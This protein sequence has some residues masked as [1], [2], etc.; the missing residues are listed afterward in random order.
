MDRS[1]QRGS[2]HRGARRPADVKRG[3]APAVAAYSRYAATKR[4][5]TPTASIA[6]IAARQHGV[7]THRRSS[8]AGIDEERHL[9]V[10][11]S[12]APAPRSSRRLRGRPH[13][14][15][16]ARDDGWRRYSPA[17]TGRVRQ[18]PQRGRALGPAADLGATDRR[19]RSA[20][21]RPARRGGITIHRSAHAHAGA[22]RPA[23]RH[24]GDDARPDARATCIAP[25]PIRPRASGGRETCGLIVGDLDGRARPHPQRARARLPA[26]LSPPS[27]SRARGATRDVGPYEVDFLWRDR[28]ADRR[29]RR[30]PLPPRP[31]RRSSDDRARDARA[32]S[33]GFGCSAS[34][35]AR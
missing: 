34:R 1:E 26:P 2:G 24:R 10:A 20:A 9:V 7:V 4:A 18:P 13:T 28:A 16:P 32:S 8:R 3:E 21:R 23:A 14:A 5:H 30:L 29:D 35:T 33:L 6:T 11:S 25:S 17:V 22:R 15:L 31:R 19:H 27:A 12:R